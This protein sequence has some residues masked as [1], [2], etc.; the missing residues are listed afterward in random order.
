MDGWVRRRARS[1]L[2]ALSK[3]VGPEIVGS[4][5]VRRSRVVPGVRGWSLRRSPGPEAPALASLIVSYEWQGPV[6]RAGKPSALP[7]SLSYSRNSTPRPDVGFFALEPER[8]HAHAVLSSYPSLVCVG[9][10][11]LFGR[12]I[13]HDHGYRAEGMR[14]DGLWVVEE[15]LGG[16]ADTTAD[17][18]TPEL[19][20]RYRCDAHVSSTLRRAVAG[21]V[22]SLPR[23]PSS[24]SPEGGRGRL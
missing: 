9:T 19:E 15:M 24:E 17:E 12:V 3:L 13:E 4:E 1:L 23:R 8:S 20:R 2:E 14:V 22:Q 21:A 10:V 16:D 5:P 6:V 18:V 7:G 11:S